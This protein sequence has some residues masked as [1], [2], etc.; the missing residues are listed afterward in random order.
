MNAQSAK[1]SISL[2]VDP[3]V[4]R[5]FR[6][7]GPRWQTRMNTILRAY[8]EAAWTFIKWVESKD[9]VKKRTLMG[10]APT[11]TWAFDDPEIVAKR[12]E[13]GQLKSLAASHERLVRITSEPQGVG[14]IGQAKHPWIRAE[15][16]S[17]RM[18]LLRIIQCKGLLPVGKGWL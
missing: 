4:L 7:Q 14:C 17:K 10:G 11:Q 5:W 1:E 16:G 9:A 18:V 8:K 15:E 2:R 6:A 13:M 12:P 3:E